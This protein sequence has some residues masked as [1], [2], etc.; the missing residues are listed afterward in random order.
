MLMVSVVLMAKALVSTYGHLPM[1]GMKHE[2]TSMPV[3][4]QDLM[5]HFEEEFHLLLALTT[6]VLLGVTLLPL[7]SGTQMTH[8]GMVKGVGQTM[9]AASLILLRGSAK[10]F[11]NLPLTTLSYVCATM[12][13]ITMKMLVLK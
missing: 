8:C 2:P 5:V 12:N 6:F 4:V 11:L 9:P 1:P 7:P 3:L 13:M 10:T